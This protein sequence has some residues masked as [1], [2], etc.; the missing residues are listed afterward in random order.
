[1]TFAP[2][3]KHLPKESFDSMKHSRLSSYDSPNNFYSSSLHTR[4]S[5]DSDFSHRLDVLDSNIFRINQQ[6]E[7]LYP[8]THML[9][10]TS[11][12]AKYDKFVREIEH[13]NHENDD[14]LKTIEDLMGKYHSS[15][16]GSLHKINGEPKAPKTDLKHI[17][18]NVKNTI[19]QINEKNE[20]L[21]TM[22]S[23]M[24]SFQ[25]NL[26]KRIEH[27]SASRTHNLEPKI[28]NYTHEFKAAVSNLHG[29]VNVGFGRLEDAVKDLYE[30]VSLV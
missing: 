24:H 9:D 26:E 11:S 29:S 17:E 5:F 8:L 28:D 30:K 12:M 21:V 19:T 16:E 1:M 4:A 27:E 10:M 6:Q 22:K 2:S 7:A 18:R 13:Q 15:L 25:N 23:N 3:K 20:V 14:R